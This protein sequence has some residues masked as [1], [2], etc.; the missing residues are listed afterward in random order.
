MRLKTVFSGILAAQL[1]A[2]SALSLTSASSAQEQSPED[3]S[4]QDIDLQELLECDGGECE[5]PLNS[6][7]EEAGKP[8][9]DM[10]LPELLEEL[11]DPEDAFEIY[12]YYQERIVHLD[13]A[14]NEQSADEII[15]RMRVLDALNPGEPIT[16]QIN[17][18]GG[19]VYDGL[20]LFNTMKSLESPVNTVCD[21]MAASMAAVILISGVDRLAEQGCRV[22]IHEVSAGTRGKTSDMQDQLRH[23]VSLQNQ[24]YEIIA[25]HSGLSIEDVATIASR[26]IFYNADESE[27]LGFVDDVRDPVHAPENQPGQRELPEDLHPFYPY[28]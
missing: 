17:S 16:L 1:A 18:P 9:H 8:L 3:L 19:S 27:R 25:E 22:M 20:R 15:D 24:L 28:P 13:G 23:V 10:T 7:T 21:G 12:E 26:D 11:E 2:A 6:D 14:V 4:G 5:A